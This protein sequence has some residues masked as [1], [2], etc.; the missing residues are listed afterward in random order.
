MAGRAGDD[1]LIS[2]AGNDDV[3]GGTGDDVITTGAGDDV[4]NDT[5][6]AITRSVTAS[7]AAARFS[8]VI[9]AGAGKDRINSFNRKRDKVKCGKGKDRVTADKFDKLIGCEKVKIRK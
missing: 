4:I 8:N 9:D 1:V 3:N 6:G 7:A 2:G 5:T